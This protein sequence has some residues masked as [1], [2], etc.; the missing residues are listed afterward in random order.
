MPH[1]DMELYENLIKTN[2]SRERL[3]NLVLV[4]NRLADY[5]DR[6]GFHPLGVWFK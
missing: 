5:I 1:C 4:A 6:Y 2:W 3:P